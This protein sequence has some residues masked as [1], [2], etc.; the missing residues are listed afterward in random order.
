MAK[1]GDKSVSIKILLSECASF[2]PLEL[3]NKDADL[4]REITVAEVDRPSLALSGYFDTFAEKR[5]QVLGLTE[6][7]YL[8]TK[9]DA[10]LEEI[11]R[12]LTSRPI[13]GIVI[14]RGLTCPPQLITAAKEKAI[15][16]M[17]TPART[18]DAIALLSDFLREQFAPETSFHGELLDMFGVGVMIL[19]ESGLGKSECAL[20]LVAKGHRM[21]ADDQVMVKR[22][23]GDLVIGYSDPKIKDHIEIQGLGIINIS[24]MYG[25][26]AIRDRKRVELVLRLELLDRKKEYDRT[27]LTDKTIDILGVKVPYLL[28]PIIPGKNIAN[29]IEA[30]ALNHL[31]KIRGFHSAKEFDRRLIEHITAS[32]EVQPKDTE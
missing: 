28:I 15:P 17:V 3:I 7:S 32:R 13:P 14:A 24:L 6:I 21:V 31:L 2:L 16:V 4:K 26:H 10:Y 9:D 23:T 8:K 22:S 11:F 1:K 20:D 25:V 29:I 30:A 19:G 5:L 27:G 18:S 12:L